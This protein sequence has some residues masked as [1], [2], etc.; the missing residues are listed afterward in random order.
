MPEGP[1]LVDSDIFVLLAGARLLDRALALLGF[2][3]DSSRRLPAL[4]HML[5]R[6]RKFAQ[7]MNPQTR[8]LALGACETVPEIADRPGDEVFQ[9]L[10]DV[11]DIDAG[12]AVLYGLLAEQ[13]A[14]VLASAD[15]RAMQAVGS[16]PELTGV[17]QRV[18]GRVICLETVLE[19][20]M[21]HDG[22]EATAHAFAVFPQYKT[23]Q[24][25]F[26]SHNATDQARCLAS[27]RSYLRDLKRQVGDDFLRQL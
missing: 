22:V 17:R 24:V 12:E 15:K 10:L 2:S 5:A 23:F 14:C 13:P 7:L 16:Q 20:L 19:L 27:L 8:K 21:R 26:S 4:P 3:R 9:Q 18:A 6:G 1:V 11:P 25:V